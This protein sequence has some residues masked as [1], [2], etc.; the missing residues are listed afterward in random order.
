M[1]DDVFF[2]IRK[3]VRRSLSSSSVDCTCA[4]LNNG[5]TALETDFLKY[6]LQGIRVSVLE[7]QYNFFSCFVL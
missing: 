5:V 6:I 1:L 4:V 2:L 7:R 3:C